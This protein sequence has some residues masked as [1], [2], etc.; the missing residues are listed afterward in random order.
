MMAPVLPR[1]FFPPPTSS[2][3][4]HPAQPVAGD[5][6]QRMSGTAAL[7]P[8]MPVSSGSISI[9][10]RHTCAEQN[11]VNRLVLGREYG[12]SLGKLRHGLSGIVGG[13]VGELMHRLSQYVSLDQVGRDCSR[14][15]CVL[16]LR[17]RCFFVLL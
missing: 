15:G 12:Q 17:H 11:E 1:T 5:V 8:G 10:L 7:A 2:V 3:F 14:S 16:P 9:S 13:D 6:T 4:K